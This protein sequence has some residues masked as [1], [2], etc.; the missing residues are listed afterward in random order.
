LLIN[1][2]GAAHR[3]IVRISGS[4]QRR[5][6]LRLIQRFLIVD[7]DLSANVSAKSRKVKVDTVE[8]MDTGHVLKLVDQVKD[9]LLLELGVFL[10]QLDSLHGVGITCA[11]LLKAI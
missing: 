4:L 7:I 8:S 2:I 3:V 11:G 1:E 6:D 10:A 9:L 5:D